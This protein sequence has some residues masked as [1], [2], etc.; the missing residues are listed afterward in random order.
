MRGRIGNM[1]VEEWCAR[2]EHDGAAPVEPTERAP[3][4]RAGGA[5][6]A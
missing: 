1:P 4:G 5:P 3:R 6:G 2:R